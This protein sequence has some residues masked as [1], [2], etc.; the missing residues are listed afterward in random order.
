MKKF[1]QFLS[2]CAMLLLFLWNGSSVLAQNSIFLESPDR[3]QTAEARLLGGGGGDTYS[4]GEI[5]YGA[6]PGGSSQKPVLVFIHGYNSDADTWFVENDMYSKAYYAGYRTAFV[7]VHHD[8]GMWDNGELFSQQLR[9]ICSQYDVREVVVVA[10]SKGGVDAD[11]ALIHYGATSRVDRVITLGTPHYGTPLADLAQSGWV[12]WLSAIFGQNNEATYVLQTGYMDYYRSVTDERAEN[13][14]TDFRTVGGWGYSGSLR[15]SGWYLNA[16]GGGSSS[17]GND[18][19]VTYKSSRRPGGRELYSGYGDSRTDFN[20][21]ELA[22]GN[23]NWNTVASQL[24]SSLARTSIEMAA[25]EGLQNPNAVVRSY[26]LIIAAEE[27]EHSFAVE[28]GAERVNI[29][30]RQQGLEHPVALQGAKL[31]AV[32]L[33]RQQPEKAADRI[34]GLYS[35]HVQVEK[36]AAGTYSLSSEGA[37]VAVITVEGG[38]WAELST[39]LNDQKRVYEKGEQVNLRVELKDAQGRAVRGAEVTTTLR[40]TGRL[41]GDELKENVQPV[42]LSLTETTEPGVYAAVGPALDQSGV[43]NISVEAAKGDFVRSIVHSVAVVEPTNPLIASV[44][45]PFA[46]TAYPNPF[47]SQ[48]KFLFTLK[49]AGQV[50]LVVRD[51]LG[52]K[53]FSI[54]E[55]LLEK[56][57]HHLRWNAG[58]VELKPGAYIYELSVNGQTQT[59]R[60]IRSE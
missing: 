36:P 40:L 11:A 1:Y 21:S 17:G 18:G 19:V 20:H 57:N 24:P 56:G 23:A 28:E 31:Q 52:R 47:N 35:T 29:D 8:Q 16:N 53:V 22:Q 44:D 50:S 45:N 51:M 48:A 59:S 41:K 46:L 60:L 30:I 33:Q 14:A 15:V 34:V 43:Y 27:G 25:Y 5:L 38:G 12:W 54:P 3:Y 32:Q 4:P 55:Q 10:H 58:E 26:S 7:S 9:T 13:A 39:D 42:P 2:T 49:E 6:V 37:Y